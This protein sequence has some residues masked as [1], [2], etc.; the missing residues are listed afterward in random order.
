MQSND[1]A[2][3]YREVI[4]G[5]SGSPA[6]LRVRVLLRAGSG[7]NQ[8]MIFASIGSA[9]FDDDTA[10]WARHGGVISAFDGTR[11]K[12]W[13]P[14]FT[15]YQRGS[16]INVMGGVG[17]LFK[18][19]GSFLGEV[20]G[21]VSHVGEARVKVCVVRIGSVNIKCSR[22]STGLRRLRTTLGGCA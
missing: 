7:V 5:F 20:S 16:L 8:G 15:T 10:S 19:D 14:Y 4:H 18:A 22:R 1:A 2:S 11:V 13:A 9:E 12:L 3:V 21:Q 17:G 6:L